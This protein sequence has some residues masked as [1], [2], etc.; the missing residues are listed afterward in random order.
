MVM[1][2]FSPVKIPPKKAGIKSKYN[3]SKLVKTGVQ[4]IICD[5]KDSQVIRSNAQYF[6]K[7]NGLT[8]TTRLHS[9]GIK[10][11]LVPQDGEAE[12]GV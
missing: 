8:I 7:K 11:Y 10:I 2:K 1:T 5:R 6:A 3:W 4:N 9:R 12:G